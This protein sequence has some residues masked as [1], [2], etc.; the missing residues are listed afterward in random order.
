ML[1]F[2]CVAAVVLVGSMAGSAFDFCL[3]SVHKARTRRDQISLKAMIDGTED[4]LEEKYSR[5]CYE[6]EQIMS[7]LA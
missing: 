4:F 1:L 7:K 6:R 5:I 2:C 3:V